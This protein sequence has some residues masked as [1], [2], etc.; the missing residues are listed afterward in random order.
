MALNDC[1][2]QGHYVTKGI[3]GVIKQIILRKISPLR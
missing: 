2:I 3:S 1:S